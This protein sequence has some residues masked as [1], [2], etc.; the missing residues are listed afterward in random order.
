MRVARDLAVN[1]LQARFH[2]GIHEPG[3]KGP[4]WPGA[5]CARP[6]AFAAVTRATP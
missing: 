1:L 2:Q 6:A 5:A 3:E 4:A